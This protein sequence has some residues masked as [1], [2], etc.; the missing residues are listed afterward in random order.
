MLEDAE[1]LPEGCAPISDER[2]KRLNGLDIVGVDIEAGLRNDGN[3]FEISSEVTR[4][5]LDQDLGG[6]LYPRKYEKRADML[7]LHLLLLDLHNGFGEMVSSAVSKI[8]E[9]M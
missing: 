9:P 7:S 3:M 6:S 8:Y 1:T 2:G 4:Q 5:C